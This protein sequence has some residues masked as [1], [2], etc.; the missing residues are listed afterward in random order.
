MSRTT[1]R[2]TVIGMTLGVSSL[3]AAPL[4]FGVVHGATATHHP[5]MARLGQQGS[6]VVVG[7]AIS[8]NVVR[9][10]VALV[11]CQAANGKYSPACAAVDQADAQA[12]S[13]LLQQGNAVLAATE[14][15]ASDAVYGA[16]PVIVFPGQTT[17][18]V[19]TELPVSLIG[20]AVN[21]LQS[22]DGS[23]LSPNRGRPA[24]SGI[25]P[26]V[27]SHD[28]GQLP[29]TWQGCDATWCYGHVRI[30][31]RPIPTQGWSLIFSF[32]VKFSRGCTNAPGQTLW[33]SGWSVSDTA[34]QGSW[35]NLG[36]RNNPNA[37]HNAE[38]PWA[39]GN[40]AFSYLDF[41]Q[42]GE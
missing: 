22:V 3:A 34:A 31:S 28:S 35:S 29:T 14:P 9:A 5:A 13:A 39:Y 2:L 38:H 8:A 30:Q 11:R 42:T 15:A 37:S 26:H 20:N 23:A 24:G 12:E 40:V 36:Y 19:I 4:S 17:S 33:G 25:H 10:V 41:V 16:V 6:Y 7:K 21:T 18:A 1:F 32:D 27:L